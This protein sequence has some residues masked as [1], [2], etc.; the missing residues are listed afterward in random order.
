MTAPSNYHS[1]EDAPICP[2]C[3]EINAGVDMGFTL[4]TSQ[5][6]PDETT[7]PLEDAGEGESITRIIHGHRMLSFI[8][9]PES[10]D[11]L[12]SALSIFNERRDLTLSIDLTAEDEDELR[13]TLDA[14][15]FFRATAAL[16]A[17][18][19]AKEHDS[20]VL[21]CPACDKV[22]GGE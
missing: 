17:E 13:A 9:L 14:R 6:A 18:H 15:A 5:S 21:N 8:P 11:G 22:Y 19:D 2:R 3:K 20:V 10:S 4:F 16:Q 1:I 12:V 7:I